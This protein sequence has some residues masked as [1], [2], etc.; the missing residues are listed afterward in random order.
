M[1][2]NHYLKIVVNIILYPPTVK[3]SDMKSRE[4]I[5]IKNKIAEPGIVE[6]ISKC[7]I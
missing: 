6:Y 1:A 5:T 4:F 2:L 7:S 3:S